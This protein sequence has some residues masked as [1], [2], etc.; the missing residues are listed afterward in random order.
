MKLSAGEGVGNGEYAGDKAHY[1]TADIGI[2]GLHIDLVANP[3][4]EGKDN[5]NGEEPYSHNAA[6]GVKNHITAYEELYV[7]NGYHNC[8]SEEEEE[9]IPDNAA[10][11]VFAHGCEVIAVSG[12]TG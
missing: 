3:S 11:S 7:L 10:S 4:G 12:N 8:R 2:V 9:H 6:D 1:Y 5:G